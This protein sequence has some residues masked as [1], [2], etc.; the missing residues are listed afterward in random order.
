VNKPKLFYGWYMVAATWVLVFLISAVV[1]S[2]FFKPMLAEFG[3][4]RAT[5]SSVQSVALIVFAL[6]S[7]FLG[8]L[9]D[10]F[11]PRLML[12]A[13]I[14]TQVSS[15]IING[16]ATNIWH[17]YLARLL[18]GINVLSSA[19]ILINNW[20]IKKRG[21][22]LGIMATG[23]PLGTMLLTPI[24]QY[25]I[26]IWGWRPT[27]FFWAGIMLVIMLPAVLFVRNRPEDKG[28]RHD[29][30]LPNRAYRTN[31]LPKQKEST[32]R[33][34]HSAENGGGLSDVLVTRAFWFMSVA[35]FICGT[36]C[37][38]M[39]THL[40]IFATDLGYSDMIG[41]SLVSLQGGLNLAGILVTGYL[42]DRITRSKVLALTHFIRS[43]SFIIVVI[44]LILEGTPL[45]MLYVAIAFFG[46]GW[47]TTAP[48]QAG[49]VADLFNSARMGTILG[50]VTACHMFGMA[51]GAYI[52][53]AIY[54]L[55]NS[56]F[57]VFLAQGLLEFT[58]FILA[59][60]I[61]K[62]IT[63]K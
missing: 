39:M 11:G 40:V 58:A 10:R 41:A 24:S 47:F 60:F 48:L 57:L 54:E 17:L 28:Y 7:P 4:D 35:Q 15:N 55:T 52:G 8:R 49:L 33:I 59:M 1:V 62:G 14:I 44:F 27:M 63:L 43:V 34:E 12:V 3:W 23:M 26:L 13:C 38:F 21:T 16:I 37:G 45:W 31:P 19:Q 36:G 51:A 29:G 50:T 6:A 22:A 18:Y 2:V 46:F 20:F 30:E 32:L 61:K 5:L 53:G 9:I 56:Y 42:S 25:L